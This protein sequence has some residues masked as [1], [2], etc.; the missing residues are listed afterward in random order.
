MIIIAGDSWGCGEWSLEHKLTHTGLEQYLQDDG[1]KVINISYGGSSNDDVYKLLSNCLYILSCVT[2]ISE[3][4]NIFVFQ[5]EW[6]RDHHRYH[7]LADSIFDINYIHTVMSNYYYR[8]SQLAM[9]YNVRIGLI[10]GCSDT[11]WLDKFEIEYPGVYIACHS[12]INLCLTDNH[13]TDN[14]AYNLL[15][16]VNLAEEI[17][18]AN[19]QN[20]QFLLDQLELTMNRAKNLKNYP[21]F[22]APDFQHPNRH[23]HLKLFDIL[24]EVL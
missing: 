13:R 5:T 7:S 6:H 14:P 2:N 19:T 22:F 21:Q 18:K 1:Y 10:G 4:K 20:K 9:K 24:R 12:M 3:V 11:I 16:P 8:L 17:E 23:G 15:Y